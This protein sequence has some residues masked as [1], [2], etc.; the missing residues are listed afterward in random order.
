MLR[1]IIIDDEEN[2]RVSLKHMLSINCPDVDVVGEAYNVE[3]GIACIRNYK[4]ELVFLDIKMPDGTGFDLLNKVMP[5][6]FRIVFVTAFEEYAMKAFK[7]NAIDYI[8]KPIDS[9]ELKNAVDKVTSYQGGDTINETI[10]LLVDAMSRT[11]VHSNRKLVL[12]TLNT[13]HV[14]E[15]DKIIR[16]ESDRNY[17][18]FHLDGD[19]KIVISR[20][21]KEYSDL[22][23]SHNFFRVHNS[24]MINLNYLRKFMRDELICILKDETA[25]PVSYRK[26]DELLDAIK[27]L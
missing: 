22:L 21:L 15:I 16:C 8:T 10:K 19:E 13:V 6:N 3:S 20:S 24:H 5:V 9:E 4:P 17:T 12:K 27:T 2:S 25:I 26:R 11:P 14:V 18:V 1:A 7:Y 23:E